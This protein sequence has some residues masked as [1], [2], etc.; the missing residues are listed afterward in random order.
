MQ[1]A[2]NKSD[3]SAV[4]LILSAVLIYVLTEAYLVVCQIY[5]MEFFNRQK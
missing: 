4:L 2:R 3:I 1:S 5:M